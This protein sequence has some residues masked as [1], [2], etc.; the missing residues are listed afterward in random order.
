ME[1]TALSNLHSFLRTKSDTNNLIHILDKLIDGL[2]KETFD[3]KND[4]SKEA[5]YELFE[6][7]EKT[8]Y[9]FCH[10]PADRKVLQDF[11]S[12]L[13]KEIVE[14]PIIHIILSIA[15]KQNLVKAIHDWFYQNYQKTVVLDISVDPSLIGGSVLSFAGKAN[16]FSLKSRIDQMM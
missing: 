8:V 7:L 12:A 14:L 5:S 1:N 4:L 3:F 11:L 15:P 13:K 2:F 16:D 10:N 9:Q 6:A